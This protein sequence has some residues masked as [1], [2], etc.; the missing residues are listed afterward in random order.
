M[1]S[2]NSKPRRRSLVLV[3]VGLLGLGVG[4][5][6]STLIPENLPTPEPV[7]QGP[8]AS[9][10]RRGAKLRHTHTPD[11]KPAVTVAT[12]P[13]QTLTVVVG[14]W[15]YLVYLPQFDA[16]SEYSVSTFFTYSPTAAWPDAD[17]APFPDHPITDAVLASLSD[18]APDTDQIVALADEAGTRIGV[19][20]LVD[21]PWDA[22]LALQV[23][24]LESR[25]DLNIAQDDWRVDNGIPD[26]EEVGAQAYRAALDA[27]PAQPERDTT[28]QLDLVRP[29][30]VRRRWRVKK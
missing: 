3:L 1:T 8:R 26:R 11:A 20:G 23:E 9:E 28:A 10:T 14:S 18:N 12:P 21:R 2:Q 17:E 6:Y 19:P 5:L 25:A 13:P 29:T 16:L 27:A 22:L 4:W 24:W 30:E 7:V 15:K